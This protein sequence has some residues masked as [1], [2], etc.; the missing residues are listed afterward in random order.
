M[1]FVLPSQHPRFL[2]HNNKQ[3]TQ[4]GKVRLKR[5]AASYYASLPPSSLL[6][7]NEAYPAFVYAVGKGESADV[8][9]RVC[10]AIRTHM[11]QQ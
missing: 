11:P 6:I 7:P 5:S 10:S 2:T 8:E 4:P 9:V 3:P 1:R